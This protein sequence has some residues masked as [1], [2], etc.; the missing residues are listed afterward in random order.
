[1]AKNNVLKCSFCKKPPPEGTKLIKNNDASEFI[2][3]DCIKKFKK[4]MDNETG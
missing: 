4:E 2:C 3:F 1:M